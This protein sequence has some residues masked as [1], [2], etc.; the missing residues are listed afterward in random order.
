M[1][2]TMADRIAEERSRAKAALGQVSATHLLSTPTYKRRSH[3][4]TKQLGPPRS[5]VAQKAGESLEARAAQSVQAEDS[6]AL[7]VAIRCGREA[8][9]ARR[10]W[11][12]RHR[13]STD[14]SP[15][16]R[17]VDCLDDAPSASWVVVRE[18][19]SV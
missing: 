7:R 2:K 1:T 16:L 8:F 14:A 9:G 18:V 15:R 11:V 6:L 10:F 4:G 5:T 12:V 17:S 19:P 13:S 3:S